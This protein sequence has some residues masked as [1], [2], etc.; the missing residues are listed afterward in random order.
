MM[1]VGSLCGI[2]LDNLD[3]LANSTWWSYGLSSSS[4]ERGVG[5]SGPGLVRELASL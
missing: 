5:S 3:G 1:G 4:P 2:R